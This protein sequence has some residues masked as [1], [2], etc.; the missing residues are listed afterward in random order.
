MAGIDDWDRVALAAL[1]EEGG[2]AGAAELP[3]R[4][5]VEQF[6]DG[7]ARAWINDAVSRGLIHRADGSRGRER[8]ALTEKGRA[9]LRGLR[10]EPG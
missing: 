2:P 3:G 7:M 8:Y 5:G 4:V 9:R 6:D 10:P 1:E